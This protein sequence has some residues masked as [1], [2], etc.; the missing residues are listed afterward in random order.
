[1][2]ITSDIPKR[3]SHSNFPVLLAPIP[4]LSPYPE[5]S[6]SLGYGCCLVCIYV[7][8]LSPGSPFDLLWFSIIVSIWDKENRF[9]WHLARELR[10]T[11]FCFWEC[12]SVGRYSQHPFPF[13]LG[14][15]LRLPIPAFLEADHESCSTEHVSTCGWGQHELNSTSLISFSL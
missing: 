3:W 15:N 7:Y 6:L 14:I 8:P 1:M 13:V 12:I 5:W 9:T 11:R 4:V 10:M 2:G